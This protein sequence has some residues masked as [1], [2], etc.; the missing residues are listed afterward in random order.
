MFY[1]TCYDK[2]EFH[3]IRT[4]AY[5][6]DENNVAT[7]YEREGLVHL[8]DH[9]LIY[10]QEKNQPL[11]LQLHEARKAQYASTSILM[12][13]AWYVEG[14]LLQ[15]FNLHLSSKEKA[16][17][18]RL[19]YHVKRQFIQRQV[20]KNFVLERDLLLLE[21]A[22]NKLHA[23]KIN[24]TSD[25]SFAKAINEWMQEDNEVL[26][27]AA[28]IYAG[29]A[30]YTPEG[31]K[32]H[33]DSVLFHTPAKLNQESLIEI[34]KI[35]DIITS[36]NLI[37]REGFNCTT[38]PLSEA[39][40]LD[41]SN[42]CIHCHNQ[43]KDSCSKGMREKET[44][45]F[46][47][48]SLGIT[49]T[50]CPLEEKISEMQ[51]LRSQGSL[52]GALAMIM[53]DNPLC[54]GTGHRICNDC[55]K[56]CIYQKQE[57]VNIPMVESQLLE[58][59]LRL[60]GGFEIYSLLTRWNP[61]NILQPYPLAPNNKK[62]LVVGLG[63]AGYT[64]SHYLL[65]AGFTVVAI[66]GLKIEP[67]T[68]A[69]VNVYGER[70]AFYMIRDIRSIK[71]N[72]A[73]R[74]SQGFGGVA[75]YGITVRWDKNQLT[76]IR[77]L[78]ERR[79]NFRMIGGVRFG[80]N[81]NYQNAKDL[82][83][84]HIALACG[85]G[86]PTLLN[87]PNTMA[88]GVRT[89]SDFLMSLQLNNAFHLD[90][91]ANL[92]ITLPVCIIGG[93]LTAVDAAT[94]A[95]AYYPVMVAKI[96]SQYYALSESKQV[97]YRQ[98]LSASE[99][100]KFLT[101]LE[102][103]ALLAKAENKLALLKKWGG[104][105]ILY[106]R[107]LGESPAYRLNHEEVAHGLA[108]GIEFME[109]IVPT[110]IVTDD[111]NNAVGIAYSNGIIPANT[112]LLAAGTA[113]NILAARD[114][115]GIDIRRFSHAI[116]PHDQR[117]SKPS[118]PQVIIKHD[119]LSVS[120]FGDLHPSYA[121]NVVKAMASAKQGHREII[122]LLSNQNA[123][124][125]LDTSEFFNLLNQQLLS[126]VKKVERL[127]P[128]IVEVLI[129]SPL[130]A[131]NFAPGQFYRLQN[132]H[133]YNKPLMEPLALT[134]AKAE[135]DTLSLIV[136]EI[137]ASSLLCQHLQPQELVSLMGPTGTP[138][139]IPQGKNVLLIGGGLGNA[140]LFSIGRAMRAKGCKVLYFAGYKKL[141]DRY[142]IA[143]IEA[144]ADHI[145]W[146]CDEGILSCNRQEDISFHGN[147]LEA[148]EYYQQLAASPLSF[149]AI[150]E[151]L[152][153]GSNALMAAVAEARHHK[154]VNWFAKAPCLT[155]SI[156]SPM[157]CMMQ[158]ICGQCIQKHQINGEDVYIYSCVMQDQDTRTVDFAHLASKLGQN[159]I[160]ELLY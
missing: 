106:R 126:V 130:A 154:W 25:Y 103:A 28:T 43:S 11:L 97:S 30:I 90:S 14:F 147:M 47:Q 78:L 40:A 19:I 102:H 129:H 15:I 1:V 136:L 120:Y 131:R 84:D 116:A 59:V 133:H 160:Q 58:E 127:A 87:I 72:L 140:V 60:D 75:E 159:K 128:G 155:A 89:A 82:G 86:K 74:R 148:M 22:T 88:G 110:A 20:L 53:V 21:E 12:E 96:A 146:C 79:Q 91:L 63:P 111:E 18:A 68:N 143:E 34:S 50:G 121:G 46:R 119:D 101:Y 38:P 107:S 71:E 149:A 36:H 6:I 67:I 54:A 142:K 124:S 52:L 80:S 83:F 104:V 23:W 51:Q 137:G 145:V 57:P 62:V 33:Q 5:K 115:P 65:Q 153:I 92:T 93:G 2:Q 32:K 69:G 31:Q 7:L 39:K 66:D 9:F 117:N 156:N 105:R 114:I 27:Q 95:L 49:L 118:K 16:E 45:L 3:F 141:S 41:Q 134:G 26:L 122:D 157:Q 8:D 138:T 81:I 77:L 139:H 56:S 109:N 29:Y 94:E 123:N 24:L 13:L 151:M 37:Q 150:D 35:D 125:T 100:K 99:T 76:T 70:Q 61:L 108:E 4:M 98:K 158:E 10:L 55:M 85:A 113:P 48:N 44:G 112:I 73:K 132:L 17:E 144:A 152:V 135:N 64:L 42:Y